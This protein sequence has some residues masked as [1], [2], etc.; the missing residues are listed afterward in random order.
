MLYPQEIE[1][2]YILP[3]LRRELTKSLI[4][5]GLNQKEIALKLGVTESAVSQYIKDKRA[6]SIKFDNAVIKAIEGASKRI[7]KNGNIMKEIQKLN[8]L[9]RKNKFI[10]KIHHKYD[11][12]LPK[13]CDVC[14]YEK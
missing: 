2:W 11:P 10:C 4:S 6:S 14:I 5:Q 13:N 1:V 7:A 9:M 3:G 8:S 12:S